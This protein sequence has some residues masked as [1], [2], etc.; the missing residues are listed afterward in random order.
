M[1]ALLLCSAVVEVLVLVT[2]VVLVEVLVLASNSVTSSL[3]FLLR[4]T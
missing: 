1:F 3:H 4:S 2:V